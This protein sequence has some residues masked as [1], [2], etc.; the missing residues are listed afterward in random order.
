MTVKNNRIALVTGV[1]RLKGIGKAICIELAKDGI[2]IFFTYWLNYDKQTDWGVAEY[3]PDIIQKEIQKYGVK[4][5]KIELNLMKDSSIEKLFETINKK[6]GSPSILIN[7]ATYST[8]TNLSSITAKELDFHYNVN[9]KAMILLTTRFIE[10]FSNNNCDGRIINLSS[11]QNL[12][13]MS[14]EIAYAVT[15][16]AV[17]TFTRTISHEIAKK[18]ITINAV[19]P[20]LTDSGW[21]NEKLKE[22]FIKRCPMGRIGQP[23]DAA[24]LIAFLVSKKA[25]WITGQIINSEGGF[26]REKYD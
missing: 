5:E 10:N 20:G 12:S 19:N 11:G 15:K 13:V 23:E 26:I 24:R 14:E 2:D 4:C 16:G 21:L 1:S 8:Q 9:L 18:N 25:K 7:N 17:E 22:L 6:M 3:E